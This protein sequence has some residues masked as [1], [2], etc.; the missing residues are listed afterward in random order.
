MTWAEFKEVVDAAIKAQGKTDSVVVWD[1]DVSFPDY[2]DIKVNIDTA[3]MAVVS[4]Q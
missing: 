3:G 1:I 4:Q 2:R